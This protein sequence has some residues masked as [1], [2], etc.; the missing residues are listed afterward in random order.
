MNFKNSR[1]IEKNT[2]K[3]NYNKTQVIDK[4]RHYSI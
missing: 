4:E 3:E 1:I 2:G